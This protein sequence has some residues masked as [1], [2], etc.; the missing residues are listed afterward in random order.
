MK[1]VGSLGPRVLTGRFVAL[2]PVTEK[3]RDGLRAAA[4]DADIFR[5]M[6]LSASGDGFGLWWDDLNRDIAKGARMVF[7]VRRLADDAIVGSTSYGNVVPE[8]ARAEIGWTWYAKAAQATAVN[9]EA[10][11]LLMSNAFETAGYHR[12]EL[13]TDAKNARSR[14]AILKL[15]AKEEG[16]LR[17]HMWMPTGY[18]RDTVYYSVLADEWPAVKA[19]L[20][21]RLA[22]H[23][24][25]E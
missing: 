3:H 17:G 24:P 16:I 8:Q 18:W 10:K 9:P 25:G 5:Y 4:H 2:E 7:A 15:G 21:A 20:E 13:K 11:L 1:P 23:R 22:A 14:A 19:G 12:V 6:P